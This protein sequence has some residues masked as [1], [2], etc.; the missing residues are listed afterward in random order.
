[1]PFRKYVFREGIFIYEVAGVISDKFV[2]SER[3]GDEGLLLAIV[4]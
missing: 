4:R 1:M 3:K 2:L